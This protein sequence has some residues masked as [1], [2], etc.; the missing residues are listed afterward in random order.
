M[1]HRHTQYPFL[2]LLQEAY[3]KPIL[4][5]ALALAVVLAIRSP[6]FHSWLG[7]AGMGVAFAFLY[8][9]A[10]LLSHF[11]DDFDWRKIE[12]FLPVARHA[13]RIFRIA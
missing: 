6:K 11:L 4:C 3:L 12:T 7:L 9:T 1:F 13:R 5:S 8:A 2:P 10:I